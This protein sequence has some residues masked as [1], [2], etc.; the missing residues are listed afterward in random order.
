[1]VTLSNKQKQALQ[2]AVLVCRKQYNYSSYDAY[3]C[4]WL[5]NKTN[6][7]LGGVDVATDDVREALLVRYMEEKIVPLLV[8]H[9]VSSSTLNSIVPFHNVIRILNK[10][11][12]EHSLTFKSL[13]DDWLDWLYV[14]VTKL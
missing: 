10:A 4:L 9:N 1:M 3:T 8:L 5:W 6:E 14:E 11:D 13:R 2:A 12:V 7:L